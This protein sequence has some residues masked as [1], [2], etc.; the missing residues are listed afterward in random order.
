MPCGCPSLA[1]GWAADACVCVVWA[2]VVQDVL[3][4]RSGKI[5]G[6]F[7]VHKQQLLLEFRHYLHKWNARANVIYVKSAEN[8]AYVE[9]PRADFWLGGTVGLLAL[10]W[11]AGAGTC[12]Q[13]SSPRERMV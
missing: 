2:V 1:P 3:F 9:V 8:P 12:G 5:G 13:T 4:L 11:G 10:S 6:E 7:T